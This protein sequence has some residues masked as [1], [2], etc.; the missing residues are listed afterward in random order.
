MSNL[1]MPSRNIILAGFMGTGKTTVGQIVADYIRWRFVDADNEIVTRFG[2]S[3]PQIFEEDGE[4]AF[5]RYE[6]IICQS[7]VAGNKQVIATGGGM[8]VDPVNRDLLLKSG[9][10]ICLTA[11]A[12]VIKSRIEQETDRPL[13]GQWRDLYT[14][15]QPIYAELPYQI[16]TTT[17]SP[18]EIA[19]KVV[20]L[21]R[22][23]ST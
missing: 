16:D 18:Q 1:S 22:T 20:A 9:L 15:R 19:E 11:D 8:V 14:E 6:R 10:V 2:K 5:R 17:S 23:S 12:D 7:L 3:I 21:W 13:V 4:A